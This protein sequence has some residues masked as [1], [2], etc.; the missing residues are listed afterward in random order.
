MRIVF[1]KNDRII[2]NGEFARVRDATD[3]GRFLLVRSEQDGRGFYVSS[4][5][6]K[7]APEGYTWTVELT[8]AAAWV[9]DGFDLDSDRALRMLASELGYANMTTELSARIVSAPDPK[10]IRLE[11]GYK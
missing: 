11:Q 7:P 2:A 10:L 8:V 9:A 3:E 5:D 4:E 6:A 1:E